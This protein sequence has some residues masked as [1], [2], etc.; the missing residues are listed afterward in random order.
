MKRWRFAFPLLLAL[1][2]LMAAPALRAGNR[3]HAQE[4]RSFIGFTLAISGRAAR[5]HLALGEVENS[6]T[7]T[8]LGH[9]QR[10][11][12]GIDVEEA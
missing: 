12:V 10:L 1:A 6:R 7:L 2:A 3:F 5:A 8:L 4:P 9:L 11:A